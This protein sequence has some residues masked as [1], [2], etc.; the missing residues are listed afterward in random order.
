MVNTEDKK[1]EQTQSKKHTIPGR[2]LRRRGRDRRR[3]R[4]RR[5]RRGRRKKSRRRIERK[6][7]FVPLSIQ[8]VF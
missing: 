4:K 5:R 3:I 1:K 2:R 7:I 8:I 6:R